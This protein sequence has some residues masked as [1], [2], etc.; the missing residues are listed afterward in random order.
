MK[1]VKRSKHLPYW[2]ILLIC[3][4]YVWPI[5]KLHCSS[6][7]KYIILIVVTFLVDFLVKNRLE[8]QAPKE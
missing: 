2:V 5:W 8:T 3:A 6:L 4:G 7:T 1:W